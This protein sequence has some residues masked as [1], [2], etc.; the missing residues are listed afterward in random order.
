[1]PLKTEIISQDKVTSIQIK[2]AIIPKEIII[3][4]RKIVI[5]VKEHVIQCD[6][7]QVDKIQDTMK[8]IIL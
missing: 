1:M 5:I 4:L 3:K 7:N 2:I 8:I 6:N